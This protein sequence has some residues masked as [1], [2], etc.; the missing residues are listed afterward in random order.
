[1]NDIIISDLSDMSLLSGYLGQSDGHLKDCFYHIIC[2][3]L[4]DRQVPLPR[5]H[6]PRQ[7]IVDV[8][9]RRIF[10]IEIEIPPDRAETLEEWGVE[11]V[12]VDNEELFEL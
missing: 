10:D 9:R 4:V 1:M 8:F 12:F 7:V 2:Q 5:S 11:D 6:V 3:R